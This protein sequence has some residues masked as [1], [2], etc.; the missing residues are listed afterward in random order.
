MGDFKAWICNQIDK[1]IVKQIV[2][3][4]NY[5]Q[6]SQSNV[7]TYTIIKYHKWIVILFFRTLFINP[8]QT[9]HSFVV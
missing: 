2:P 5:L 4:S 3:V 9:C 6:S 7:S 8:H 1:L